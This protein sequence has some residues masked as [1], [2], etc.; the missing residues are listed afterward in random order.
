MLN[1]LLCA[2]EKFSADRSHS[3]IFID[4]SCALEDTAYALDDVAFDTSCDS[5]DALFDTP[6]TVHN[7]A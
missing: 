1:A 2:E 7:A 5:D 3:S 4:T 6:G